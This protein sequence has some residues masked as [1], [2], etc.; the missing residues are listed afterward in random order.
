MADSKAVVRAVNTLSQML[1]DRG[2]CTSGLDKLS[3]ADILDVVSSSNSQ[4]A[5]FDTGSR[6][7][8]LFLSKSK[9][10]DIVKAAQQTSEQRKVEPILVTQEALLSVQSENVRDL[11][12]PNAEVFRM[13]SL[14]F[15]I[16]RHRLVP[17]HEIYPRD[18]IEALME[19]LMISSKD[20]LP[21]IE[22]SDPMARYIRAR[23][24]DVVKVT[25]LCPTSGTQIAYRYC[26]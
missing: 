13:E 8:I 12:G 5:R 14:A 11:F 1:D 15:S 3:D 6:D 21:V 17:K 4:I 2:E 10:S 22:K 20:K 7:V 18:K 16:A 24:G 23:V 9:K 19:S 26:V 25:R